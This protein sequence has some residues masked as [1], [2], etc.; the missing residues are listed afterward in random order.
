MCYARLPLQDG[1]HR[2][3]CTCSNP[4]RRR[5]WPLHD[6]IGAVLQGDIDVLQMLQVPHEVIYC[7]LMGKIA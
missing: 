7:S 4:K 5:S 2:G 1:L 3:C 6:R